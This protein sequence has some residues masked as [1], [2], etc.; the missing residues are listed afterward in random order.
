MKALALTRRRASI[1]A[2]RSVALFGAV[3][4]SSL[5]GARG[6]LLPT[7]AC[8]LTRC[9][10][11]G[12]RDERSITVTR[13][14]QIK[15][16]R[17][18]RGLAISGEQVSVSVDAPARLAAI[19]KIEQE[20]STKG[21]FP[22][23]LGPDGKIMA[24]GQNTAEENVDAAVELAQQILDTKTPQTNGPSQ[25]AAYLAQIQDAGSSVLDEMPG[26]LFFPSTAPFREVRRIVL[27]DGSSGSFEMR[28]QASTQDGSGLLKAARREVITRIGESAR[29][30]SEEWSLEMI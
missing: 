27:P 6:V 23:L 14:W 1:A 28:W 10:V 24:I 29:K 7:S 12:L 25:H 30:S 4:P 20:R 19:A 13:G 2:L 11:R 9:L 21:L 16:S 15:F 3:I 17:Q 26:D 18:A 22:I 5:R 8:L